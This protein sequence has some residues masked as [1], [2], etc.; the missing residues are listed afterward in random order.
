MEIQFD[1]IYQNGILR[2]KQ[3]LSLPDGT[4]VRVAIASTQQDEDPLSGVIGIGEGPSA[5]DVAE[6][7][8]EYLYDD[9]SK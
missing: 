9:P 6:K 7:H 8:D 1:A 2:P 3:P 5:G 4:E